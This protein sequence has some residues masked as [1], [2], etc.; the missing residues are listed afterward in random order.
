MDVDDFSFFAKLCGMPRNV[1]ECRIR[2]A[3]QMLLISVSLGGNF[4]WK[5][6]GPSS[7]GV[8]MHSIKVQLTNEKNRFYNVYISNK[9]GAD[10]Y[11]LNEDSK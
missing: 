9:Y 7:I 2:F 1:P 6:R 11:R 4:Q 10:I 8:R 5:G 3:A